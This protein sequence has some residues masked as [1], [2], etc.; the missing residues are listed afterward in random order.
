MS[1]DTVYARPIKHNVS[2]MRVHDYLYDSA[3]IVSGARDYARTAFKAAMASAQV[4]L[5]PVYNSMFADMQLRP[6]MQVVYHPNCRLPDHIDRSYG[7]YLERVK[8]NRNVPTPQLRGKD[9]FKFNA[10]P[11]KVMPLPTSTPDFHPATPLIPVIPTKPRNRGTQSLYRE[12]SAQTIPWQPDGKANSECEKTP[13]MLYLDRLQWGYGKPYRSGDLPADFHTTEIINKMRHARAWTELVERGMFP[14]WMKKRDAIINDV[15]TKDWIFREAEI[16]ELQD[17]RLE[18]LHRLQAE[19]RQKR[20]NRTST[21]LAKLWDHKKQEMQRKVEQIRKTRDRELRKLVALHEGGGR[22]GLVARLRHARGSGS[23][24]VACRDPTSDLHAPLARHGYQA[25]RRHANII[26]D[27][28]LLSLEDHKELSDVPAWL[29]ECSLCLK[30]TCSGHHLPHDPN[31]LCERQTKWSEQFLENLHNDLKKARLGAATMTAGPLHVLKS[32]RE[33]VVARPTTPEVESVDD[34]EEGSHQAAL[35]LQKI[36]RGRA[37][38]NL[39]YEGRTRAAELTEELKTTHGLQKEDK[40][41]ISMEESKAREFNARRT[42]IEQKD[43]A[44]TALVDE[45]CGGAV[46]AALDF[47]EKELRRLKEERR[48]H[49]FLLIAIREKTMREAA[50]AGRRQKEE[51]RRR[52]HDEM[53]KQIVGVTQ[54]TVDAYLREIIDEGVE[55]AAEED[56][57]MRAKAEALK[58]HNTMIENEDLSTADTNELVAELVQQFLLPHTHKEATRNHIQKVQEAKLDAA[59]ATIFGLVDNAMM[60]KDVCVRCDINPGAERAHICRR[61]PLGTHPKASTGRHDPRWK[62]ARRQ[63]PVPPKP[64][65]ER[66]PVSH[67]VRCMLSDLVADVVLTSRRGKEEVT[68]VKRVVHSLVEE[69]MELN[70]DI[71]HYL[72]VAV[73]VATGATV[74]PVARRPYHYVMQ[75]VIPDALE[76]AKK[77]PPLRTC[78]TLLPS[79]IRRRREEMEAEEGVCKCEEEVEKPVEEKPRIK[80]GTPSPQERSMLLPSELRALERLKRCKCDAVP[81]PVQ[82]EIEAESSYGS[83]YTEATDYFTPLTEEGRETEEEEKTDKTN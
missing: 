75:R 68:E 82:G 70:L 79:E 42:E 83:E 48:Q 13:E 6:R 49:A 32:R 17:I 22:V 24:V 1:G 9:R 25:R 55:L 62:Y 38:Q 30:K 33:P 50:E 67:D 11:K 21:K 76:R 78:P 39:M 61:C 60:R 43:D 41:R 40:A 74:L 45:L 54:G 57:M 73:D 59:R 23:M 26:Y 81:S 64:R 56:A 5:Q 36:I 15:E 52:E 28:T 29:Q 12:S 2:K 69:Q 8:E 66:F 65:D 72:D 51:H 34:L 63:E 53:F 77:P 10:V 35:V 19:Q 16:D 18:L 47:L 20:T 7:A 58:Y 46:S 44:I 27:P 31:T 37:V 4:I 3:Y 80:F 71:K 14:R